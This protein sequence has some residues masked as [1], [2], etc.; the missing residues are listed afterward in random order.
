MSAAELLN[1]LFSN[2]V[3]VLLDQDE[4][5]CRSE[6]SISPETI[7]RIRHNKPDI[8]RLLRE[9]K[10]GTPYLA[11]SGEFRVRGGLWKGRILDALL[12]VGA[13]DDEIERHIGPVLTPVQWERW[14][15][16]KATGRC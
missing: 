16:I 5:V 2:G 12:E 6:E 1:E 4:L 7:T 3:A 13:S 11:E 9:R 15:L 8:V 14:L 10:H